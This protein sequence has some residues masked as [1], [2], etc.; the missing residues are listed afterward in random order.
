MTTV[1]AK[2]R[3]HTKLHITAPPAIAYELSE[4]FSFMAENY[5]YSPRYKNGTWDGKIRLFNRWDK[6]LPLGLYNRLKA[7]CV[8]RNYAL[9]SH[10]PY[11]DDAIDLDAFL[12]T[13]T[14]PYA[15]RPY[16][17][18]AVV[19]ALS[20]TR[21]TLISPT[22]SGKTLIAFLI[23]KYYLEVM[24]GKDVLLVV[25]NVSLIEQTYNTF[26][27]YGFTAAEV[28]KIYAQGDDV[29]CRRPVTISTWQSIYKQPRL[30]FGRFGMVLADE[31][32]HCKAKSLTTIM[33]HLTNAKYRIGMTGTLDGKEVNEM[34]LV[35]LL[36][37]P[38]RTIKTADLQARGE[39]A[40]LE[41]NIIR[42]QYPPDVIQD[43]RRFM[44]EDRTYH[45]EVDFVTGFERRNAF[46]VNLALEQTGN[47]LILFGRLEHG[48]ALRDAIR[49]GLRNG[50]E[51]FYV[52]GEVPAA[53]REAIRKRVDA[54]GRGAVV[55]AS[56]GTFSTGVDIRNIHHIIF[57][58]SAKSQVRVLQSI[59]RGLRVAAN[60]QATTL[61][62]V[63]D[64]ISTTA[65]P[66]YMNFLAKHLIDR[67]E[68]YDAEGFAYREFNIDL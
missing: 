54:G 18:A 63:V 43:Y 39:L 24:A 33:N 34:T 11:R 44:R 56:F 3:D 20:R 9:C 42:L 30:W 60:R 50:R 45:R 1:T 7:F 8:D 13:L 58:A 47:T 46:I 61:T 59:G 26:L 22:G 52:A 68:I 28:A 5:R 12:A 51:V 67:K 6:T 10:T 57:A 32:H 55:V 23:A 17:K 2:L 62:D 25:P 27:K 64:V 36:G 4:E 48:K 16:Q 19:H 53:E 65:D 38:Y 40:Q 66:R 37:E 21:A 41:T 15:P 14:L 49:P 29:T 35:G 31:A